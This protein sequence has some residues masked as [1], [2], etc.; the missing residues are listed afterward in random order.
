MSREE[1]TKQ[2]KVKDV[3]LARWIRE[4]L[5]S[6]AKAG[7]NAQFFER[8][9][10]EKF[11]SDYIFTEEVAKILGL[12]KLTVQKWAHL[13]RLTGTCVSG[14]NIDGHHGYIFHR[15]SLMQWREEN[16]RLSK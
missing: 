6:P 3:T 12:S 11:I 7:G 9:M 10:V 14:P 13:G 8:E 2:L 16:L 15:A 5:I 4:G 1:L